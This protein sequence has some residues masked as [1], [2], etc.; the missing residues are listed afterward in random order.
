MII[1]VTGWRDHTDE[2]FIHG[3][4]EEVFDTHGFHSSSHEDFLVRV[5]DAA[6]ADEIVKDWCAAN[7]INFDVYVARRYPSGAL[8]PG[9]GPERNRRL[10]TYAQH[11]R[12]PSRTITLRP[13]LAHLLV[14]F[15]EPG[16]RIRIP[17]SG[18]WG[19]IST[20]FT[21]RIPVIIPGVP[22]ERTAHG[23]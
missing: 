1:A 11:I 19:C 17:G 22:T 5:G 3:A 15:P 21:L 16:Q 14:G 7:G 13:E 23:S 20:A 18:S 10:L 8:M 4:M 12:L 6:G 9:A 2:A